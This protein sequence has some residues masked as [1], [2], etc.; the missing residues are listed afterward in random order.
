MT[1]IFKNDGKRKLEFQEERLRKFIKQTTDRFPHLDSDAFVDSLTSSIESK[2]EYPAQQITN[3]ILMNASEL[4]SKE[5]PDWTFVAAEIF[6]RKLYKEAGRNRFYNEKEKYGSLYG[7]LK[8]LASEGI[9]NKLLLR[10]YSEE[11]INELEAAIVPERDLLFNYLGLRILQ[12]KYLA[13]DHEF[14]TYELPQERFMIIAMHIMKDERREYRMDHV[15]EFYWALSNHYMTVATP[16][17]ANAGK[18]YG[19]LSSCFIQTVDDDL[20]SIYE[21]NKNS[22]TLSKNGGGI[23]VYLGKVRSLGSDIKG[24]KGVGGGVIPWIKNI[25]QTAVAVDQLGQRKGAISVYLDIWHKDIFDF[26]DL[27]LNTG[28]ERKRAHDI[29]TGV[30]IP[31]LFMEKVEAR[32]NWFLFDP[33]EVRTKKGWSI[34]DFFDEEDH[35]GSFR[36][37]YNELIADN[38]INKTVV[39]A[40]EIMKRI[41]KSQLEKGVPFMFYRDEVNRKNANSH[42]GMI[43]CTNLCTEIVQN[44]SPTQ[45]IS[46][47]IDSNTGEITIIKKAGEMVVCNLSSINLARAV[48]DGVLE[49]LIPIQ[50]RGLDNVIDI[51]TIPVSEAE[52]TNKRYRS[53]GLGT[54]GWHQLLVESGIKWESDEA[55]EF[56]DNL[57]EKIAFATIKAS[58]NLAKEK[59][60]Y[61]LFYGSDWNTGDYFKKRNYSSEAWVELEED[62][63]MNG[64]RNGYL[65]AVAPN[66]TTALV[67]GST[68][69]IDP[70]FMKE[71]VEEKKKYRIKVTAPNISAY[72]NFLYKTSFAIDQHTSI[73]QNAARQKHIDQSISFN[74]YVASEIKAKELL[75]LHIHAW[76]ER[77]KTT[78][79]LR[80]K[81]QEKIDECES[82]SS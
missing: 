43:Y 62:V 51:N 27:K 54:F 40:I 42:Q 82:C 23:G 21:E 57:Y 50:V 73:M 20:T 53:I 52:Y 79:Y 80:T 15:K 70:I 72:N 76:K 1:I 78:Y 67:V 55:V 35:K 64:I 69:S 31:D 30:C 7:L 28:D 26:L 81:Q 8:T 48:K 17:F 25:N 16:S 12:E 61:P 59:G 56:C 41:M 77:L 34:E 71:Y 39:P 3:L 9:Y 32:E 75:A 22:A 60:A 2:E 24:F 44:Q 6:L 33:H 74:L 38:D 10:D 63:K 4:T 37:K 5:E 65:Q 46:E 14:N 49:R 68:A 19:Q 36:D 58:N 66:A 29:F 13:T 47:T 18:A 45:F 11:E